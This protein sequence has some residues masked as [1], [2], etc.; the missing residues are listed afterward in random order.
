MITIIGAG[1]AGC[2]LGI[3]LARRGL[4]VDIYEQRADPRHSPVE[5]GRSINLALAAR[6]IRALKAA[7]VMDALMPALVMMRGR[8]LHEPG[9][10][11]QFNA[12][13]QRPH[14]VI[15]SVSR[16]TLTTLLTDAAARHPNLRLNFGQQCVDYPGNGQLLMHDESSGRQY[17]LTAE[18]IIGAD[19]AG[20]TLRHALAARQGFKVTEARLPHDYKELVIP[21]REGRPPLAM[22]ALHIWPRGGFMLIAL[23]NADGSFTATLFLARQGGGPAFDTLESAA[24][25][26][27][28][29]A[30]HFP[31][32]LRLVPDLVQQFAAHPQGFLGTVYCPH[33]HDAERL[34][35]IGDAAHAI[36]PF[37]GQGMNCAFEDCRILDELLSEESASAFTTF[38]ASRREDCLAIAQMALENYGEMRDAVRDPRFQRQKALSLELELAQ[39]DRFVPRYSMVMFR[40]D[41]PYSQALQRGRIQQQILEELTVSSEDAPAPVDAAGKLISSR[42]PPLPVPA[43]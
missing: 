22:D 24:K 34:L 3:L 2:L 20:S 23:P 28:F 14:E 33:W 4:A 12:Y 29:F 42:L 18:R 30:A 40:D 9:R 37:H 16:T 43:R 13:G 11:D 25:V 8:M 41:I 15:W 26:R 5:A 31:D 36:V 21:C 10:P 1:P 27:D 7:G 38:A 39:P 6:G 17:R 32:V 19:G 35:L